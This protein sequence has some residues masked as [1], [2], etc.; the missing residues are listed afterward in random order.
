MEQVM[1]RRLGDIL[2]ELRKKKGKIYSQARVAA[3][4]ERITGRKI[5]K[6]TFVC[7]ELN[8]S[9]PDVDILVH[10][11]NYYRVSTDYLLGIEANPMTQEAF[12]PAVEE[13]KSVMRDMNG[14][15]REF[16]E[17]VSRNYIEM[18]RKRDNEVQN[19]KFSDPIDYYDFMIKAAIELGNR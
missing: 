6:S 8:R 2:K 12:N 19:L 7:W 15:S 1:A 18:I 3:D 11:A 17:N 10:L 14:N 16:L 9:R 13:M 4:I 5:S